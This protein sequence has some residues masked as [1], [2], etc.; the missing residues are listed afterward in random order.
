MNPNMELH[1]EAKKRLT[2][3]ANPYKAGSQRLNL[4]FWR[5]M[6]L[7]AWPGS[8]EHILWRSSAV[9]Q[10]GKLLVR[11]AVLK[12]TGGAT[13]E[14]LGS[15]QRCSPSGR[16]PGNPQFRRFCSKDN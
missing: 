12:I 5:H 8:P 10:R 9:S 7:T 11:A 1:G 6:N 16:Q 2:E 13:S 4:P 14:K 3:L 15:K